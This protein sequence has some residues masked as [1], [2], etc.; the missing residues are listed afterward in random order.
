MAKVYHFSGD[1]IRAEDF[2]TI[3]P[4]PGIRSGVIHKNEAS[5]VQIMQTQ[6]GPN[7]GL[8]GHKSYA[9]GFFQVVS[10]SGTIYTQNDEGEVLNKAEVKAG[11]MFF[12]RKPHLNHRYEAGPDGLAYT[13]FILPGEE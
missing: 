7:G 4:M 13:V 6:I 2:A 11:D 9:A 5:G 3:E 12:Y 1:E 8:P 10:G